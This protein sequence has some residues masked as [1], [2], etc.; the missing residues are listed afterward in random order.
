MTPRVISVSGPPGAGKSTLAASL[1]SALGATFV[2]YDDYEVI[3]SWPPERV[4]GWLDDGA[5]FD[6]V[7]A[8]G[9]FEALSQ[10]DGKIVLETP[11]GRCCPATGHL[12]DFSVWLDCPADLAL[13][14]KLSVLAENA[15][16]D[17][18]FSAMLSGW[19]AAYQSFTRRALI[20]QDEN[21]KPTADIMVPAAD[22]AETVLSSVLSAL[23]PRHSP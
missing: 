21:V 3:T 11:F 15:Q 22:P 2:E 12:I 23:N 4:I 17:S 14:R 20:L 18:Q 19:L 9:L 13:A 7:I 5:P 6:Q 1:A 16:Q 10:I 8:P